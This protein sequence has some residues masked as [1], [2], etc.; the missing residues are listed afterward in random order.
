M[1]RSYRIVT[2]SVPSR[3]NDPVNNNVAPLYGT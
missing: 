2:W 3:C 1:D